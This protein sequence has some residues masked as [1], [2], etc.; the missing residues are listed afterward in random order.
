MNFDQIAIRFQGKGPILRLEN[1]QLSRRGSVMRM[2][3]M[4]D[5]RRIGQPDFFRNVKLKIDK[6]EQVIAVERRKK[7]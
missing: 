1:S 3:G 6:D 2:E 4:L 7:F 5:V